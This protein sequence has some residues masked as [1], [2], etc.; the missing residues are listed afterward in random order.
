MLEIDRFKVDAKKHL[1]R[2]HKL[3]SSE[4]LDASLDALAVFGL[5]LGS[6]R[7]ITHDHVARVKSE[8]MTTTLDCLRA[9]TTA[10]NEFDHVTTVWLS[11][12]ESYSKEQYELASAEWKCANSAIGGKRA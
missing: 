4:G 8:N 2:A 5:V 6:M 3:I 9:L 11:L 12:L 10:Q 7:Q 1:D